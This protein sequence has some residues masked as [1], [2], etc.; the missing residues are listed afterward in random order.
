MTIL[1]LLL[2]RSTGVTKSV[3]LL[4]IVAYFLMACGRS[5]PH[6]ASLPRNNSLTGAGGSLGSK[7][8]RGILVK[9]NQ[10]EYDFGN[11]HFSFIGWTHNTVPDMKAE[12]TLILK[13]GKAARGG[14]CSTVQNLRTEFLREFETRETES[15]R[16]FAAL[17]ASYQAHAFG[18]IGLE[19]S[20]TEFKVVSRDSTTDKVG[21]ILNKIEG[22]CPGFDAREIHLV[23]P[24]PEYEFV[25]EAKGLVAPKPLED[26]AIKKQYADKAAEDSVFEFDLKTS[27]FSAKT[28][29]RID[30]LDETPSREEEQELLSYESDPKLKAKLKTL[31]EGYMVVI[32]SIAPRDRAILQNLS[33]LEGNVAIV[34]GQRHIPDL[35]K[36]LDQLC[37]NQSIGPISRLGEQDDKRLF[38]IR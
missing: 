27:G 24:G 7:V 36:Q 8:C 32:E 33:K 28:L 37:H 6:R 20:P 16:V 4:L 19:L 18:T 26:D 2:F 29:E 5:A 17:D 1:G 35:Q 22:I 13:M 38:A 12:M 15:A 34:I 21:T 10:L 23:S 14:D 11:R 31:Y 30:R 9:K 25:S 3:G